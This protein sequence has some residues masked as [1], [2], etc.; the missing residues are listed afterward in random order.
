MINTWNGSGT[1]DT[2]N[3]MFDMKY[4]VD[5][6][7]SYAANPNWSA[8][9]SGKWWEP[10][11]NTTTAGWSTGELSVGYDTNATNW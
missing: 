9:N 1:T 10:A 5:Y 4:F 8:N 3:G 6:A 2:G 11:F 7:S